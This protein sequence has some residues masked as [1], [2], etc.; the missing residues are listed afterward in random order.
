[1]SKFLKRFLTFLVGL[2]VLLL[3][4]AAS[5]LGFNPPELLRVGTGYA[6]KIVCSNVFIAKRDADAVLAD[7]VQAPGNPLLKFLNVAVD[8]DTDTVTVRIFGFFAPSKAVFLPGQGCA[9]VQSTDSR[10]VGSDEAAQ[11]SSQPLNVAISDKVQSVIEDKERAG[12]GMRAIAV[13]HNGQLIAETYGEGF[14]ADTPLLGWSMTKSVMATLIGMRIG[15][16]RM[17]LAKSDLLPEWQNDERARI[18]IANLMAMESGL[19]FNENYGAVADVTRMLFLEKDMAGFAASLPLEAAPGTKFNYS[20][21]T[22]NILSRLFMNSFD[23]RN[24]ALVYPR[25]ALFEPLG[26]SSA[27]LETDAS[28][29]FAGSSYMYATAR[30]WARLGAFLAEGGKLDGRQVLPADF[31]AF[32]RKPSAASDGRYGSAQVWLQSGGAKAGEDGIPDDAFWM[33]GHDGQTVMI[34]PSLHLSVVRLGLTPSRS[35]Y[36]VQN[37]DAQ[38]I[39]ALR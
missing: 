30:D 3:V 39:E 16:N 26:M 28:G 14:N 19:R 32:M 13:I 2:V 5:W 6:A 35:G 23:S 36:S 21:G 10:S 34:V 17:D 27:L 33:S 29:V 8:D 37:L 7:D 25:I 4:G 1:M 38:I 18:T 12:A 11:A 24:A 15:E 31:V 22:A 9:N 20:S